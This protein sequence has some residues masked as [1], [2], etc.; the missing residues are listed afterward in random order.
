MGAI[1]DGA[2]IEIDATLL[3]ELLASEG[4]PRAEVI[5]VREAHEREAGHIE[6][7]RHVSLVE[8]SGAVATIERD[9]P[10]VF[11]CRVGARS[12]MAAEAF[13]SAGFDAYTLVG[14]LLQWVAEGRALVPDGGYVADH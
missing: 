6:G 4:D 8:L 3:A 10:V 9:R 2:G 12:Q 7:T 13:R 11:Y 5:D 1:I 14:G